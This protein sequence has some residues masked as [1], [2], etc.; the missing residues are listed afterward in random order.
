MQI[1]VRNEN[2]NVFEIC[3]PKIVWAHGNVGFWCVS[4][5]HC[6]NC[7]T[8]KIVFSMGHIKFGSLLYPRLKGENNFLMSALVSCL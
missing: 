7:F 6:T 8:L 4:H 3:S 1:Y 2:V 5:Y